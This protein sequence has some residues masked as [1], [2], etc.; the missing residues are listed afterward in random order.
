MSTPERSASHEPAL[1]VRVGADAA[2]ETGPV[3]RDR[4][5]VVSAIAIL[6]ALAWLYILHLR[7]TMPAI[8]EP[9]GMAS[10]PGM[11]M[12][13]VAA[14]APG[15]RPWSAGDFALTL[16]MWTVMMAGMMLPSVTPMVWLYAAAARRRAPERPLAAMGW[17][18]GGYLAAW[19][20]FSLAATT[21]QWALTSLALIDPMMASA[22]RPLGGALL[23]AAGVYQWSP[24]KRA[25]LSHCQTPLAFVM[26]HG[27]FRPGVW[28]AIREGVRHGAYC[29]GC[30]AAL[31]A[32]LFVG[33]VM[34][35]VWIAG[36][37]ILVLVEKLW[38]ASA[39]PRVAGAALIAAALFYLVPR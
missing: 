6:T 24:S 27:G 26:R 34:N 18:V 23:L 37:S 29:V 14:I 31:M 15:F 12:G 21:A 39:V 13:D 36:L 8:A 10:M 33:G 22:S 28:G 17:F 2:R 35:V 20:L 4:A 38:R 3:R 9:G 5:I 1:A 16:V 30:C 11:A 19:T 32:L 7:S 25:C